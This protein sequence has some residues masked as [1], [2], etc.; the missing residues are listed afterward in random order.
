M[1]CLYKSYPIYSIRLKGTE[2]PISCYLLI[3]VCKL[4]M[5]NGCEAYRV[6]RMDNALEG[7]T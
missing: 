6:Q 5:S 4:Q 3:G 2:I 7:R 1:N